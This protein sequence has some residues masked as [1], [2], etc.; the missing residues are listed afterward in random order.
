M[1]DANNG[2]NLNLAKR[3]L[4]ETAEA[5]IFWL[6]EAFHEHPLFYEDLRMWL[7]KEQLPALIA[8]GQGEASPRLL[9]YARD[10]LVDVIQLE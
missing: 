4:A 8:D 2:Y 6:E 10:G 1:I 3:A 9:E 5:N 7:D